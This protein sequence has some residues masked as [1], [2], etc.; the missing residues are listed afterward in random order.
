MLGID[1]RLIVE[2]TS[3]WIIAGVAAGV[4]NV[5]LS[6]GLYTILGL[7]IDGLIRGE[8]VFERYFPWLAALLAAKL[9]AGWFF[10]FSQYRASSQTKLT[11]RDS[12]YAH[13]LKLGPAVLD[14]KRTGEL[15]NIAVDGMDWIEL[16]YG[17]YFIQFIVGMATPIILCVYIGLVDF[18]CFVAV[19][20]RRRIEVSFLTIL[21]L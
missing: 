7:S 2:S 18:A 21:F 16:F 14:R 19:P 8:A 15:V 6:L 12:V 9:L 17:V 1:R 3:R 10:R 13:A 5:L 11:I 20:L 4:V